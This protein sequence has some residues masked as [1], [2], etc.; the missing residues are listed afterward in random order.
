GF[1]YDDFWYLVQNPAI[2]T[3]NVGSF[4][5]QP[6]TVAAPGS[7]LDEDVYRPLGTLAFAAAYHGWRLQP[8]LYHLLCLALHLLNGL[9]L[10]GLLAVILKDRRA[11]FV[12]T[13][14]FLW[15]P[16]Q[17]Q[18]VAWVAQL[19]GLLVTSGFLVCLRRFE[20]RRDSIRDAWVG[21][22]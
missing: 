16:A 6:S 13:T 14:V 12:G 11:A 17:V 10:L 7:G 9:L 19:P 1:V 5:A 3:W 8:R 2:R 18:S 22:M 21:W 20:A 15:H 4:F